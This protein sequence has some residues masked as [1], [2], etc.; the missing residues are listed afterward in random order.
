MTIRKLIPCQASRWSAFM[1]KFLIPVLWILILFHGSVLS[2][3]L[4]PVQV[5][6]QLVPPYSLKLSDYS[7]TT[8]EKLLVNLLL[9]DVN[10]SDLQVRLRFSISGNSVRIQSRNYVQNAAPIQITGGVPLRLSNLDLR[11]YFDFQNLEGITL[12][13]YNKPLPSG[14]YQFCFEVF[15]WATGRPLS[16]KKCYPV[17][18]FLNDPPFLNL[19]QRGA[20]VP[21]KELQNIIF[22]WTPRHVNA[23]GVEYA[24][25]LRE[26]WDTQVD[27]QTAFLASPVL[28]QT[29]SFANTLLYGPGETSLLEGKNYGWRV[30]AIVSDGISKAAVFKNDGYSEIFY[31]SYT[32][33]CEAPQYILAKS[34]GTTSEKITWQTNP[35]HLSYQVQFRKAEAGNANN[36]VWFES[37]LVETT[38]ELFFLEKATTYEYR[39]GGQCMQ[40]GG[41]S[42]SAIHTFTT[43]S[44]ETAS[45]YNCGI[46]PEI[47]ITNQEP[48]QELKV[49]DVFTA[50]DFEV[51][52][53]EVSG[54]NGSFSGR[55]FIVVPYLGN[56]KL[57]VGFDDIHIN[58][59]KQLTDGFVAT[60]YTPE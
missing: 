38:K 46:P 8:S 7:T 29:T 9:T 30:R 6:P 14:L 4:F 26:L 28:Y 44:Q 20:Q 32:G 17:Y 34:E 27:P 3:Q 55:G 56:T 19:P 24:F 37:E 1:P 15:D 59:D 54:G 41:Y 49:D 23:T 13:E 33:Q 11:P 12:N 50:G 60:E 53:K 45:E 35:N 43:P 5:A 16:V 47:I 36:G 52:V 58:T 40:N 42:Y 48:L 22:Q 51:T 18:L 21:A 25:E 57:S 31:F 10:E 2:A 39:V